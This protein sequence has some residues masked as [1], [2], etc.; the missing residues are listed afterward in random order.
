MNAD[1]GRYLVMLMLLNCLLLGCSARMERPYADWASADDF[2][3]AT[4]HWQEKKAQATI[5]LASKM[6]IPRFDSA[7]IIRIEEYGNKKGYLRRMIL[8]TTARSDEVAKWYQNELSDFC[9]AEND[10]TNRSVTFANQCT[11]EGRPIDEKPMCLFTTTPNVTVKKV[12][13]GTEEFFGNFRTLI[14]VAYP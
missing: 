12:P 4:K 3:G 10:S 6:A 1:R 14:E 11:C 8:A 9:L 7:V 5:P 2:P 13:D